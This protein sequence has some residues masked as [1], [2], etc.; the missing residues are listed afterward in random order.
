MIFWILR[1][2]ASAHDAGTQASF[3]VFNASNLVRPAPS[4]GFYP[5]HDGADNGKMRTIKPR[6]GSGLASGCFVGKA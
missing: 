6:S 4:W 5:I 1:L 3:Q 2:K